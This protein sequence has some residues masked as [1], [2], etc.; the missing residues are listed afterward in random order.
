MIDASCNLV[1]QSHV[2]R[3]QLLRVLH[4]VM[5]RVLRRV[6]ALSHPIWRPLNVCT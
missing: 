5:N 1:P 3:C 2:P 4:L 6:H